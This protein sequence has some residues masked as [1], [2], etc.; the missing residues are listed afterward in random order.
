MR[1]VLGK[2]LRSLFAK[3]SKAVKSRFCFH[4]TRM[5]VTPNPFRDSPRLLRG[6]LSEGGCFLDRFDSLGL[7]GPMLA[8]AL[9]LAALGGLGRGLLCQNGGVGDLDGGL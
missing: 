3:K 8:L 9:P 2:R 6:Y 1:A 7:F 4:Q 5:G